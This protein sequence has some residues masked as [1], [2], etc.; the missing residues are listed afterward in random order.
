MP[1]IKNFKPSWKQS[2]P[3]Y[4]NFGVLPYTFKQK[5]NQIMSEL[6]T[7]ELKDNVAVI[8][9]NRP[10]VV[11]ALNPELV[12]AFSEAIDR[13][14]TEAAAIALFGN[15]NA[16]SSGADLKGDQLVDNDTKPDMGEALETLF[17]PLIKKLRNLPI[18]LVVGVQGAAAGVGCS[19]ALMGDIIVAGRSAYFLQ[20]F[21]NVGLVPDGGS[22]FLL[23][24]SVG[25]IKAME[26][27]L[28]GERYPATEAYQA[29]LITRLV[30]DDQII[31]TTLSIARKLARGPKKTLALI[32]QTAWSALESN[33]EDQLQFERENQRE[34]GYTEDFKEGVNAFREKRKPDFKGN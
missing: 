20:A 5:K 15:G 33:F 31:E 26:L 34:A 30:D 6:V 32:R 7:Y 19:I 4:E 22:A 9:F 11:N 8:S 25:R 13:A 27:M 23:A 1:K 14:S 16:F 28:L 10:E 21:C 24:K 18:P 29:G 3:R 17:N 12:A 2:E